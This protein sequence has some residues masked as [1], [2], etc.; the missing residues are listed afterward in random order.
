MCTTTVTSRMTLL[1]DAWVQLLPV[2]ELVPRPRRVGVLVVVVVR[3]VVV[4]GV[5]P[6]VQLA[7]A[8]AVRLPVRAATSFTTPVLS[9]SG[10]AS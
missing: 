3:V 2:V 10:S 9:R 4:A 8:A 1:A 5:V 7:A 6:A